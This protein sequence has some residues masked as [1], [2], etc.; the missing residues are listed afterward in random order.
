MIAVSPYI[1]T[2][3]AALAAAQTLKYVILVA[4]GR[5]FDPLRQI[6][7]SGNMPSTHGASAAALLTIVGLRDGIESGLFGLTLLFAI[8]V[9]YD[10]TMLR[11]SVGDQGRAMQELIKATKASV[12]LPHAAKGH[13]PMELIAGAALG[14]WIGI[15]V[16]FATL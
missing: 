5:R 16:F 2:I 7:A 14:V 10:A 1:I 11:R 6:Y 15:V 13:T 4:R 8:I 3:F 9:M 12:A